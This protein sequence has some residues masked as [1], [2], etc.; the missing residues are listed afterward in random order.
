MAYCRRHC[1]WKNLQRCYLKFFFAKTQDAL[2]KA[3]QETKFLSELGG[4]NGL[5]AFYGTTVEQDE[6]GIRFFIVRDN[7]KGITLREKILSGEKIDCWDVIRQALQWMIFFERH[8][9][10]HGDIGPQN[11]IYADDGKIYP[12]DYEEMWNEPIVL[13]WPYKVNL[14][15]LVYRLKI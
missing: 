6:A 3:N 15:F 2:V 12:I 11:F 9:Y 5:P 8:G 13:I 14:L 10:Y 4:K 7:I 1:L